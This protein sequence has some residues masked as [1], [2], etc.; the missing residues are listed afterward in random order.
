MARIDRRPIFAVPFGS[1]NDTLTGKPSSFYSEGFKVDFD[2]MKRGFDAGYRRFVLIQPAGG[3]SQEADG[4]GTYYPSAVWEGLDWLTQ[5]VPEEDNPNQIDY[6]QDLIDQARDF[7]LY[8]QE[9]TTEVVELSFYIGFRAGRKLD[10]PLDMSNAINMQVDTNE[11]FTVLRNGLDAG[12]RTPEEFIDENWGPLL[13][14]SLPDLSGYRR[15]Y[16]DNSSTPDADTYQSD[17]NDPFPGSRYNFRQIQ[18]YL[19]GR[20]NAS[21]VMEAIPTDREQTNNTLRRL[22]ARHV[23][24]IPSMALFKFWR[25]NDSGSWQF[26]ENEEKYIGYR[27]DADLP[28]VWDHDN[29]ETIPE[30]FTLVNFRRRRVLI[31]GQIEIRFLDSDPDTAEPTLVRWQSDQYADSRLGG[32]DEEPAPNPPLVQDEP[33]IAERLRIQNEATTGPFLGTVEGWGS[34]GGSFDVSSYFPFQPTS[35]YNRKQGTVGGYTN[36]FIDQGYIPFVYAQ[37]AKTQDGED[38]DIG[39]AINVIRYLQGNLISYE[40]GTKE[41]QANPLLDPNDENPQRRFNYNQ[42]Y[43]QGNGEVRNEFRNR[44]YQDNPSLEQ[45]PYRGDKFNKNGV[46]AFL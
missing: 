4:E 29:L 11:P 27:N 24:G 30:L 38:E 7:Q 34:T 13:D 26:S 2:R 18:A 21:P 33:R 25:N 6:K 37:S 14:L 44:I 19:K 16:F 17:F 15:I 31:G 36:T 45:V 46:Y 8:V 32:P 12:T 1:L 43:Y 41:E 23:N 10:R 5:N 39:V 35:R 22:D 42:D 40:S 3:N 9:R 20:Y 28:N